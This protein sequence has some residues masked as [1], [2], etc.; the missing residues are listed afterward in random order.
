MKPNKRLQR[1]LRSLVR[2]GCRTTAAVRHVSGLTTLAAVTGLCVVCKH[3]FSENAEVR[4]MR[5][6]TQH[7]QIGVQTIH[8]VS[9]VRV[10]RGRASLRAHKVHYLVLS[11]TRNCSV[12]DDDLELRPSG[13]GVEFVLYPVAQT[14][15]KNVHERCTWGDGVGIPRLLRLLF[16]LSLY[17]RAFGL[18][19]FVILRDRFVLLC[20]FTG[21]AETARSLLVHLRTRRNTVYGDHE[22]FTRAHH[23][24][25]ALGVLEDCDHHF[26]L[27]R[28]RRPV[29]RVRTGMHDAV[30]VEIQVVHLFAVRVGLGG[31]HGDCA[32]GAISIVDLNREFFDDW[33]DDLGVF[34]AEPAEK[35]WNTHIWKFA[36]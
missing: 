27:V 7:D 23:V 31:V 29:L 19:H 35:G 15:C 21:R 17:G 9:G 26:L 24:D 3:I 4:L 18:H 10:M 11:L 36:T 12:G 32:L 22:Q 20:G 2:L 14:G 16:A 28:R 1:L 33:R 13:V 8:D 30:H 6:K 25:Y 34:G 5:C